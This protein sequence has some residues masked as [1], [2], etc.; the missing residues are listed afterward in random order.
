MVTVF[1][2]NK[3]VR[4]REE[5]LTLSETESAL[6]SAEH[7]FAMCREGQHGISSKDVA[8]YNFMRK[9]LAEAGVF[10]QGRGP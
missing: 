2:G 7:F 1:R 3:S 6:E 9:R 8:S 5:D 10:Y 4:L